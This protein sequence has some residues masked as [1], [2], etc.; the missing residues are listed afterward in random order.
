[1]LVLPCEILR[2]PKVVVA[3]GAAAKVRVPDVVEPLALGWRVTGLVPRPRVARQGRLVLVWQAV[4]RGSS[5][6]IT[7]RVARCVAILDTS[8]FANTGDG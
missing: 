8:K 1:M 5:L 4:G 3:S 7:E 6:P 2:Q